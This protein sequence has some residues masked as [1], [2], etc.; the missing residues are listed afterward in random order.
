MNWKFKKVK[1]AA[2]AALS[3]A[4]M[5]KEAAQIGAGLGL[6]LGP[7][8]VSAQ[9]FIR[10]FQ[11]MNTLMQLG[12][13]FIILVGLLG[14]L[15]M[16]LGGVVSWYKKYDRGNDDV[17]YAKIASQIAA[18]GLGMALGWVGTQVVETLGGSSSDIGRSINSR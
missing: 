2:Y 8:M 13:G 18:G 11:N 12:I 15:G 5:Y 7:T 9:G 4:T 3:D 10:G 17:S 1:L 14:G 16:V 6:L